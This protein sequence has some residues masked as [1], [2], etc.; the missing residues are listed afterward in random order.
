[1]GGS[2]IPRGLI[3]MWNGTQIPD[4][5][6]LCNGQIVDDLQTP[7]LSGK[8]IVGWQSGNEDYNLIGNT[9]GKDKVTLSA[10]EIPAHNHEF[11]DAYFVKLFRYGCSQW[12]E[13]D[14]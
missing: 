4:G 9:G 3:A 11:Q 6:A 12:Y 8:F 14:W 7:D 10:T 2:S 13:M 1:M 5:W